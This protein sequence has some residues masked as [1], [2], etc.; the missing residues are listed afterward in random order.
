MATPWQ[1]RLR[2]RLGRT[3]AKAAERTARIA[4]RITSGS[5]RVAEAAEAAR[6]AAPARPVAPATPVVPAVPA[7]D[8][9][10]LEPLP[11]APSTPRAPA[12]PAAPKAPDLDPELLKDM[13]KL[14]AFVASE[15]RDAKEL[16]RVAKDY[17]HAGME[18]DR[19]SRE[20][21]R[22]AEEAWEEGRR[23]RRELMDRGVK[24]QDLPPEPLPP[25]WER[26]MQ[27]LER[28]PLEPR[29]PQPEWNVPSE[30]D[31]PMEGTHVFI[32]FGAPARVYTELYQIWNRER[33]GIARGDTLSKPRFPFTR[34]RRDADDPG[35]IVPP[36]AFLD[37]ESF[38]RW[39]T[40]RGMVD[41]LALEVEGWT[42]TGWAGRS[43]PDP[44][45]A[46]ASAP[47]LLHRKDLEGRDEGGQRVWSYGKLNLPNR[48]D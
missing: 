1:K 7:R 32:R 6:A 41:G 8:A 38:T 11:P 34:A 18:A 48:E 46:F 26:D 19:A 47:D 36:S 3:L 43:W 33:L 10:P 35:E 2:A 4:E 24:Y 12:A 16:E 42:N 45:Q 37:V 14:E 25:K 40:S 39:A 28:P 20:R 44:D 23:I 31:S 13:E 30:P 15:V 21:M 22:L 17:L 29:P 27:R 5:D 9:L